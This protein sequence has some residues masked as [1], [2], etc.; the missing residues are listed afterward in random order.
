MGGKSDEAMPTVAGDV[1]KS[2]GEVCRFPKNKAV[3]V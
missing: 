1:T 3:M 2:C